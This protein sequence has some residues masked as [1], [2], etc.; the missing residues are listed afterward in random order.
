MVKNDGQT[1]IHVIASAV[2]NG[3]G[4]GMEVLQSRNSIDSKFR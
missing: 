3:R 2:K 4:N 1:Q